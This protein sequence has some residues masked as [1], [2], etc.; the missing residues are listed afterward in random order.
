MTDYRSGARNIQDNLGILCARKQ[1]SSQRIMDQ[2][3]TE[4]NYQQFPLANDE[5]IWAPTKKKK[6]Q[7]TETQ[8]ISKT[9]E[10]K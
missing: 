1:G 6:R 2:R 7:L 9:H 8:W 4:A 10:F 5:T 3:D